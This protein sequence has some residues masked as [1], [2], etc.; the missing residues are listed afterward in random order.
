MHAR[1]I[2]RMADI[3][4]VKSCLDI[5][6]EEAK[7]R[8]EEALGTH[9]SAER[10]WQLRERLPG[11]VLSRSSPLVSSRISLFE[12]LRVP[13]GTF[14]PL[15]PRSSCSN[16]RGIHRLCTPRHKRGNSLSGDPS[17]SPPPCRR[18]LPVSFVKDASRMKTRPKIFP[19]S[20]AVDSAR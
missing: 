12:R 18:H 1:V 15:S 13:S 9:K 2:H 16:P 19:D 10:Y 17:P 7:W 8:R 20:M 4:L 14:S 3:R 5:R 11:F 6:G